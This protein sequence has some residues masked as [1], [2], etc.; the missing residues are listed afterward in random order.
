MDSSTTD[1]PQNLQDTK[2]RYQQEYS[3]VATVF[4]EWSEQDILSILE[5]TNGDLDLTV[6]RISEGIS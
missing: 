3:Y 5:D 6:T 1:L 4:A 2:R